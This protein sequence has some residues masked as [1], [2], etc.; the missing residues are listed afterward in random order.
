MKLGNVFVWTALA[1]SFGT[2]ASAAD[3]PKEG[4]YKGVY[5]SSGQVRAIPVGKD[6]LLLTF[7]E[8]HGQSVSDGF[9]DHVTWLCWGGGNFIKGT[10]KI[11]GTCLGTD[12]SGDQIVDD[13][14]S[15]EYSLESK[16]FKLT[17]NYTSGTGKYEGIS[18]SGPGIVDTTFK[19]PADN[20][21]AVRVEM[22]GTYKL[23]K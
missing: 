6:R 10:G 1:L 5:T 20:M 16:S 15:E 3:L 22:Q 13:F 11:K 14:T 8:E 17:D 21:F 23:A 4:T 12:Q 18:G 19:P 9:L 2:I 7:F